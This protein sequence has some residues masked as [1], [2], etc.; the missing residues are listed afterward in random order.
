MQYNVIRLNISIFSPFTNHQSLPD[1]LRKNNKHVLRRTLTDAAS[2]QLKSTVS[3]F[4]FYD[5]RT[6]TTQRYTYI[7]IYIYYNIHTIQ[8]DS[9]IYERK[10]HHTNTKTRS[11][12]FSADSWSLNRLGLLSVAILPIKFVTISQIR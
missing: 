9:E 4:F 6:R 10:L 1:I 3:F 11:R 5:R 2:I 8:H 7:H 12:L